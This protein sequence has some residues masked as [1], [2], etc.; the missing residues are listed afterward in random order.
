MI[1]LLLAGAL[2]LAVSMQAGT[3]DAPTLRFTS[4]TAETYLSGPVLLKVVIDPPGSENL[5]TD[6]TF[7]AN[8]RQVCIAPSTRP[9]CAWDAGAEVREQAIRAVARL[10]RGGR[11]VANV[12]GIGHRRDR[13][14][15][16][17]RD[18]G[19]AL[20]QGSAPKSIPP[21]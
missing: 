16:R 4:P 3:Q 19:R 21:P 5:V 18:R 10:K 7:F 12:H 14:G 17:G 1:R 15:Q 2:T 8:G 9:E 13:A 6:V 20:R 11:I